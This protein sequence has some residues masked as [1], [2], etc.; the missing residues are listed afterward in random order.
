VAPAV[1]VL[2]QQQLTH[3]MILYLGVMQQQLTHVMI[4]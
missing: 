1:A 2:Q 3:V 4:L